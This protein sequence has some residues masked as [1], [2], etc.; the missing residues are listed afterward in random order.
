MSHEDQHHEAAIAG[1]K[2][3]PIV[4]AAPI[5]VAATNDIRTARHRSNFSNR[6]PL[7]RQFLSR[8][9]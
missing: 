3:E 2:S 6:R 9:I 4:T 8:T 1:F 5:G 7:K